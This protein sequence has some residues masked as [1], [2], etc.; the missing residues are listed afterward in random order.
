MGSFSNNGAVRVTAYGSVLNIVLAIAKIAV[1]SIFHSTALIADGVHSFSDLISDIVIIIGLRISCLPEDESHAYGHRRVETL[2][3]ASIGIALFAVGLG[4][5]Y[6]GGSSIFTVVNGN[7]LAIPGIATFVVALL[8]LCVKEFLFRYT[9]RKGIKLHSPVLIANAWH[10]RSDAYSSLAT[11]FGI[12]GAILL[13]QS[14]SVLDPIAALLVSGFIIKAGY[15]IAREALDDLIDRALDNDVVCSIRDG[16]E[17]L[18][19]VYDVHDLR[20][21]KLGSSA[22]I[23]MHMVVEKSFSLEKAHDLTLEA[24]SIVKDLCGEECIVTIHVDPE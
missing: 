9:K 17:S 18:E 15:S 6:G 11:S 20:T 14:W 8:S 4:L 13:G 1:G 21:R 10:H 7:D 5:F 24:E 22:A 2:I 23:E 19:G 3:T 12:G 16:I